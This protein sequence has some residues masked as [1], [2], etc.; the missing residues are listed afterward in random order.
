MQL[1]LCDKAT[2]RNSVRSVD[3]CREF[4]AKVV[5]LRHRVAGFS[6]HLTLVCC[7]FCELRFP[8]FEKNREA[9]D[10]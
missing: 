3:G 7:R 8:G 1:R 10:D 2:L 5:Q 4:L 6:K 9:I